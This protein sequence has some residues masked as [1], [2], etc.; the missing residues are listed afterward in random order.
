MNLEKL[1]SVAGMPGIYKAIGNKGNGLFIE[2]LTADKKR[3]FVTGRQ[4]MITPLE[5]IFI[6][7]ENHEEESV[8]LKYIYMAMLE[9]METL[10]PATTKAADKDIKAYFYKVYPELDRDR[11]YSSDM[12][13]MLKWFHFLNDLGLLN[14]EEAKVLEA[15][16]A[17]A[18]TEVAE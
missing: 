8:P 9:Q 13:K 11:V 1:V 7:V 2:S 14:L 12:K 17:E 18:K 3:Q 15:K 10:P 6:F 5:S 4:G 16:A